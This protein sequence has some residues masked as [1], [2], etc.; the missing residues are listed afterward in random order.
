MICSLSSWNQY[1][2]LRRAACCQSLWVLHS[3]RLALCPTLLD[4][5]WTLLHSIALLRFDF[6]YED[7]VRWLGGD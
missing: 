2:Q 1:A 7:F 4:N 6:D 3:P 5:F